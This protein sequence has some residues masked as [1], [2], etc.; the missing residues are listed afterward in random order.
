[1]R[2]A[3]DAGATALAILK[4]QSGGSQTPLMDF[5]LYPPK[6]LSAA[7]IATLAPPASR[8]RDDAAL[9]HASRPEL[10]GERRALQYASMI[11]NEQDS[12]VRSA[13]AP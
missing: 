12:A 6:Q 10:S 9:H 13:A 2:L 3:S 1:V 4:R 11:R 7:A 5:Y 8:S